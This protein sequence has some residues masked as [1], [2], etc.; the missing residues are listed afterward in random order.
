MTPCTG[1]CVGACGC[2]VASESDETGRRSSTCLA[3]LLQ[4]WSDGFCHCSTLCVGSVARATL[5]RRS[6][7]LLVGA[8]LQAAHT[9]RSRC[10]AGAISGLATLLDDASGELPARIFARKMSLLSAA[11]IFLPLRGANR[12]APCGAGNLFDGE[13]RAQKWLE[14]CAGAESTRLVALV[15]KIKVRCANTAGNTGAAGCR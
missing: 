7:L 14:K 5:S 6:L 8:D 12:M 9:G 3:S 13:A 10:T 15:P 2:A 1:V 4:A 11:Q